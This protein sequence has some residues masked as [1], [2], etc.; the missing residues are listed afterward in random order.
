M[1]M[2]RVE[3]D[4]DFEDFCNK[5][6]KEEQRASVRLDGGRPALDGESPGAQMSITLRGPRFRGQTQPKPLNARI[7]VSYKGIIQIFYETTEDFYECFFFLK[8]VF[9]C[10]AMLLDRLPL[11]LVDV[12]AFDLLVSC[13]ELKQIGFVQDS[14]A[15]DLNREPVHGLM[16]LALISAL[17]NLF[18][19]IDKTIDGIDSHGFF[20]SYQFVSS[21]VTRIQARFTDLLLYLKED[22]EFA[23]ELLSSVLKWLDQLETKVRRMREI[24]LQES[25]KIGPREE[26]IEWEQTNKI[27]SK[28]TL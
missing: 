5:V 17:R 24:E 28:L 23:R 9:D 26:W 11:V 27:W 10:P 8:H 4:F 21:W 7:L 15:M 18:Q 1:A 25:E 6:R 20:N 19:E 12:D 14:C 16:Y 3:G 2:F 22:P 13:I